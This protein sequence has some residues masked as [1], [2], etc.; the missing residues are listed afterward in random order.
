M[1]LT[2]TRAATLFLK[3]SSYFKTIMVP[4]RQA[5]RPSITTKVST[6]REREYQESDH[7]DELEENT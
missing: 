3:I 2:V 6:Q 1:R 4:V 5:L 7:H